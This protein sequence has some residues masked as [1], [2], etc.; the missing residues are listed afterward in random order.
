M[1]FVNTTIAVA[2][3]GLALLEFWLLDDL[4]AA[5]TFVLAALMAALASKHWLRTPLVRLL[6]FLSTAVMFCC[7]W[8]FFALTPV[9]QA[10]WYWQADT[11]NVV[12]MLLAGFGMIPVVAEYSCRMKA[13]AECE[14]GQRV[15][16]ERRPP[17]LATLRSQ[18]SDH[19]RT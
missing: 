5:F 13:N 9:L 17:V 19:L 3:F 7:F 4:A 8:R 2:L 18:I 11:L 14:R 12:G 1:R 10:N 6:A 15:A 16:A